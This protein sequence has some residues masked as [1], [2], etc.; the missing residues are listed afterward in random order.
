MDTVAA[1]S[2]AS[3]NSGGGVPPVAQVELRVATSRTWAAVS[4]IDHLP[5]A[6]APGSF[7]LFKRVKKSAAVPSNA[8]RISAQWVGVIVFTP[9]V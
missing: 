9:P 1:I 2:N 6:R 7:T 5:T 8:V 4:A 3:R